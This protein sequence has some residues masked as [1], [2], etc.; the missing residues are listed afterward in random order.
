MAREIDYTRCTG[1][2]E[3]NRTDVEERYSF[4][5]Y[6]GR[7]CVPCCSKYRD[8]CGLTPEGQGDQRL[9][10]EDGEVIDG[11]GDEELARIE[12]MHDY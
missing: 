8:K 2:G 11:D 1:C 7:L 4:G 12:R 5:I 9:L 3:E 6:A 10:I